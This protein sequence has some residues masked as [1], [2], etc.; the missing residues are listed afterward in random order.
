MQAVIDE[1]TKCSSHYPKI[2]KE[3]GKEFCDILTL[4]EFDRIITVLGIRP[5]FVSLVNG[6][7]SISPMDYFFCHELITQCANPSKMFDEFCDQG[8]TIVVQHI[9]LI[10]PTVRAFAEYL[11]RQ[12]FPL[13]VQSNCYLAPDNAQGVQ[14]HID[15]HHTLLLQI[16]GRKRW[17]IWKNIDED[18]DQP[19]INPGMR[20]ELP[21]EIAAN[22]EPLL[23]V[24]VE[25]GDFI[26]IPRGYIHT[27]YTGTSHSMHITFSIVDPGELTAAELLYRRFISDRK[28][29]SLRD[30]SIMNELDELRHTEFMK[31]LGF[32]DLI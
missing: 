32:I 6:K 29:T 25:S 15:Q 13:S 30:V 18:P 26:F 9:H 11:C 28:I 12:I 5:P 8:A 10:S 23:D 21:I 4:E 3:A 19:M 17:C 16:S 7:R 2:F 24:W 31:P 20:R 1:F 22:S 27:P 14:P